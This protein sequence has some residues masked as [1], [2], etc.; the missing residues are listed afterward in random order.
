MTTFQAPAPVTGSRSPARNSASFPSTVA[1]ASA[2]RP[3][4]ADGPND[5]DLDVGTPDSWAAAVQACQDCPLLNQCAELARTLIDRGLGPRSMIWAGVAYDGAGRVLKNLDRHRVAAVDHKP[6]LRI[7]RHGER[8]RNADYAPVAP[9]RH[10]VLGRALRPTG[11][12]C[13]QRGR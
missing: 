10:L 5:W 7:I 1:P 13:A 8:P 6:P 12:D 11:S 2:R 3:S 9:R 4:C